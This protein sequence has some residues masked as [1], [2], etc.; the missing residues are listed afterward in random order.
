M[1]TVQEDAF[2]VCLQ[3]LQTGATLEACLQLYPQWAAAFRPALEAAQAARLDVAIVPVEAMQR[4]RTALLGRAAV[5]RAQQPL[6][7]RWY[8]LLPRLAFSLL[9]V[10]GVIFG[11]S[12]LIAVSAQAIPG[13]QMYPLKRAVEQVHLQIAPSLEQKTAIEGAY[14][15]RRVEEILRLFRLRRVAQVSFQGVVQLQQG[16]YWYVAGVL[17]AMGE[18]T[19]QIGTIEAGMVV[20]VEGSTQ[21]EGWVMADEVHLKARELVGVV[22]QIEQS[23][24]VVAGTRLA[25]T[26]LSQLDPRLQVGDMALVMLQAEHDGSLSARAILRYPLPTA[27]PVVLTVTPPPTVTPLPVATSTPAPVEPTAFRQRLKVKFEGQ[28]TRIDGNLWTVGV[29]QVVV[30]AQTRWQ[31]APKVGDWVEVSA[32]F[33]PNGSLF[34]LEIELKPAREGAQEQHEDDADSEG[35]E[36]PQAPDESDDGQE[37]DSGNGQDDEGRGNPENGH[38]SDDEGKGQHEDDSD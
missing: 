25:I 12:G 15:Q 17:V 37:Q 2:E 24:W 4:S 11:G 30:S 13:D 6:R 23:F 5:L 28:V 20:E 27:T 14:Q 16:D 9:L 10:L 32:S 26:P 35:Q 22:Q 33:A 21:P 3:A 8:G 31:G 36:Q 1:T 7:G 34:A 29:Q 38:S 19:L 18:S